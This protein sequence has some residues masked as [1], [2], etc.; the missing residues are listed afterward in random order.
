[1][2]KPSF[3]CWSCKGGRA[4]R[5]RKYRKGRRKENLV[6]GKL[7]TLGMAAIG[8]IIGALAI[9]AVVSAGADIA[10]VGSQHR[11]DVAEQE[12]GAIIDIGKPEAAAGGDVGGHG[13]GGGGLAWGG[14]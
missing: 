13:G 5:P 10:D 11:G 12:V 1:V 6:K 9:G 4:T 14:G 8:G 3:R 2:I 7:S